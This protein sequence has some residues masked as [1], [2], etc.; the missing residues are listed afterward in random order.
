MASAAPTQ[1]REDVMPEITEI[2]SRIPGLGAAGGTAT[3]LGG[4]SNANYRV[5]TPDGPVVLRIPNPDPGPFIDRANEIEATRVAAEIGIGPALL[6]AEPDGTL[7]TRWID[8]AHPMSPSR[9][10]SDPSAVRRLGKAVAR[11]HGSGRVL[12]GR[13]DPR[14]IVDAYTASYRDQSGT[15]PWGA[16][17]QEILEASLDRVEQGRLTAVPSHCDPVPENC[18]DDGSRMFLVDWEYAAMADPAWDLA[19]ASLEADFDEKDDQA[20]LEAYGLAGIPHG[21]FLATKLIAAAVNGLWE[22][23]R[24]ARSG[25]R[26]V[27]GRSRILLSA[28]ETLA[29]DS[30]LR[31]WLAGHHR[32]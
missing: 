27:E 3:R 9:Y 23:R 11:L 14:R 28:A 22:L 32:S 26:N 18:L 2:L 24:S 15:L 10:R 21:R 13:Y 16:S 20:L 30:R 6:H 31:H 5:D 4:R 8:G 29:T 19:Y 7:A 12:A 17:V 1:A 25:E